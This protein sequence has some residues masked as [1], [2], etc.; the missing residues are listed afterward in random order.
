MTVE[1]KEAVFCASGIATK[2]FTL[3]ELLVVIAIIALL[4]AVIIPSL[5]AAKELDSGVVCLNNQQQLCVA[6]LSYADDNDSCIVG[7]ST[8]D[9][10]H[11]RPTPYRWRGHDT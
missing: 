11:P 8:Y 7:G 9:Q 2:G 10:S 4:L 1:I 5:K 6:W 3:I